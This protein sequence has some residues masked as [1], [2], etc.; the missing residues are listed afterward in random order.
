MA[1]T[2]VFDPDLPRLILDPDGRAWE[3]E[4]VP[5][6]TRELMRL[7]RILTNGAAWIFPTLMEAEREDGPEAVLEQLI[8]ALVLAIP[9]AEGPTLAFIKCM[10]RLPKDGE[11]TKAERAQL[12]IYL[13][14]P[15]PEDIITI[16]TAIAEEE[17]GDLV[18]L[19]KRLSGVVALMA[20]AQQG[21]NASQSPIPKDGPGST[22]SS[23]TSSTDSSEPSTSSQASTDGVTSTSST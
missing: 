4:L 20:K 16:I 19:G 14:N 1:A 8:A 6:R 7:L 22:D 2:E 13:D 3:V 18:S 10:V 5:M 11:S 9:E 17:G 21:K 15:E 12:D 23:P